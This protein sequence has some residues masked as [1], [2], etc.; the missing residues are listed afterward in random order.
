LKSSIHKVSEYT[1]VV[2][3][4]ASIGKWRQEQNLAANTIF[5]EGVCVEWSLTYWKSCYFNG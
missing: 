1:W 3:Q 4:K 2:R 5:C